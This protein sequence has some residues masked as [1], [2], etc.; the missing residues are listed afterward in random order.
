MYAGNI[1]NAVVASCKNESAAKR[2]FGCDE[3]VVAVN[4]D[5]VA[6]Q[7]VRGYLLCEAVCELGIGTSRAHDRH[8]LA[9]C[10]AEVVANE[11]KRACWGVLLREEHGVIGD[12]VAEC[13][14]HPGCEEL[15][16][17]WMGTAMSPCVGHFSSNATWAAPSGQEQYCD[18]AVCVMEL[19]CASGASTLRACIVRTRRAYICSGILHGKS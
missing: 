5:G 4:Q 1:A 3:E 18:G 12:G 6:F 14:E 11:L 15:R 7:S 19:T 13:G 17:V 8:S 16:I 10:E 2:R 9:L